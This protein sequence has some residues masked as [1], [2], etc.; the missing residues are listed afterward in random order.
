MSEIKKQKGTMM[1]RKQMDTF[2]TEESHNK[3]QTT[4][5]PETGKLEGTSEGPPEVDNTANEQPK[6]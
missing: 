3:P 6:E 2:D 4:R 1:K 5:N